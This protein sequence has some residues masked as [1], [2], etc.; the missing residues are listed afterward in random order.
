MTIKSLYDELSKLY[1]ENLRAE[2]DN[3]GIMCFDYFTSSS[4][5]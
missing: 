5:V 3:D 4:G 2:W 1:P